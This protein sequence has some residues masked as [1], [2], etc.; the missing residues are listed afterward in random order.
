MDNDI[1]SMGGFFE[2]NE[3]MNEMSKYNNT[4][5]ENASFKP[6]DTNYNGNI[7]KCTFLQSG[8]PC[9]FHDCVC[10]TYHVKGMNSK[11]SIHSEDFKQGNSVMSSTNSLP[12]NVVCNY[13]Q[14]KKPCMVTNCQ[15]CCPKYEKLPSISPVRDQKSLTPVRDELPAAPTVVSQPYVVSD[16]DRVCSY[17]RKGYP[18]PFPACKFKCYDVPEG[19]PAVA[20]RRLSPDADPNVKLC[21]Y[22]KYNRPC[23]FPR[24]RYKCYDRAE[25]QKQI[26]MGHGMPIMNR[27]NNIGGDIDHRDIDHRKPQAPP[28]RDS[29][30][31]KCDEFIMNMFEVKPTSPSAN[32]GEASQDKQTK[33]RKSHEEGDN[34]DEPRRKHSKKKRSHDREEK[35]SEKSPSKKKKSKKD[36]KEKKSKKSKKDRPKHKKHKDVLDVDQTRNLSKDNVSFNHSKHGDEAKEMTGKSKTAEESSFMPSNAFVDFIVKNFR[37]LLAKKKLPLQLQLE[38]LFKVEENEKDKYSSEDAKIQLIT[39]TTLKFLNDASYNED[40]IYDISTLMDGE[41]LEKKLKNVVYDAVKL[42]KIGHSKMVISQMF[43][44]IEL[45]M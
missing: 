26:E 41:T 35:D 34:L 15:D 14:N 23:P 30:E 5:H 9:D 32:D 38:G 10:K 36:K 29:W 28:R 6:K 2:F 44:V 43:Q 20:K 31:A 11:D 45:G 39:K 17:F 21:D 37:T 1:G 42:G 4:K 16:D 40:K 3:K 27:R 18:C 12:K 8:V 7:E 13:A 22:Y 33:K 24:C 19:L 25:K